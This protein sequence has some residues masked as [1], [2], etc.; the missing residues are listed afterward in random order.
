MLVLAHEVTNWIIIRS[1]T[2]VSFPVVYSFILLANSLESDFRISLE[3]AQ[4]S[5]TNGVIANL[6]AQA[7]EENVAPSSR[8]VS[9]PV[10]EEEEIEG[11]EEDMDEGEG[12][13]SEDVRWTSN[14]DTMSLSN[15]NPIY[16]L[17][18][19]KLLRSDRQTHTR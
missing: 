17:R 1:T 9:E 8:E 19:L 16:F 13:E 10:E 6:E 7:E 18:I 3:Y 5:A 15:V 12:D 4:S 11:E 14:N 2:T